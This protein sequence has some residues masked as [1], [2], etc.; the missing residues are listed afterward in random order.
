MLQ[1]S[2]PRRTVVQ[3]V[4][5]LVVEEVIRRVCKVSFKCLYPLISAMENK[6]IMTFRRRLFV[7][8]SAIKLA[9]RV[10]TALYVATYFSSTRMFNYSITHLC[11]LNAF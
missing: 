7:L 6:A 8:C 9:V 10:Q 5:T 4:Q 3:T 2:R 1:L 11:Q